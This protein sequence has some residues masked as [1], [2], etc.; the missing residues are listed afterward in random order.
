M[1]TRIALDDNPFA[2]TPSNRDAA[3]SGLENAAVA[4]QGKADRLPGGDKSAGLAHATAEKLRSTAGYVREHD[5]N[6]M[7]ADIGTW[8]KKNP[9][10]SLV[11]AVAVGF[12]VGRAFRND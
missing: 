8:V 10:S 4:L 12:L 7:I 6:R 11:A 3:A 5:V 1:P 9:G 2:E